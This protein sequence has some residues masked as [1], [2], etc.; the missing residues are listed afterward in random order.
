MPQVSQ[1]AP[2]RFCW[3]EL[4]TSDQQA[5]KSFYSSL[6]GWELED[7]PMGPDTGAVYTMIRRSGLDIGGMYKQ[8]PEHRGVPPHWMSYVAVTSADETAARAKSLGATLLAEPFD[9]FDIGRMATVRDPQGAVLSLWQARKHV[10]T[11][12]IDEPGAPTWNELGARDTAAAEKFYA[13]LF[14]WTPQAMDMPMGKYTIFAAKDGMAGGMYAI[15]PEM[16]DMPPNWGIYF[17]VDDCDV[18][19]GKAK[20]LGAKICLPPTDVPNVGRFATLADP[21]G[22]CFS[23][24]KMAP[25][26]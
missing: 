16:G 17:A 21:Q 14:G 22:A 25:R 1:H 10:G 12:I 4:A 8:G 15:T 5:A 19:T 26:S 11:R 7:N 20:T 13:A 18:R 3:I 24:I 2:G 6:L 23:I 9:V